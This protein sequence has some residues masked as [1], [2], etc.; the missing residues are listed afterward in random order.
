MC[1]LSITGQTVSAE[2]NRIPVAEVARL[3]RFEAPMISPDGSYVAV[4]MSGKGRRVVVVRSL[5]VS[6]GSKPE[7]PVVIGSGR[8]HFSWYD[9]ANNDRLVV[10][11]RS[12]ALV[13]G[14]AGSIRINTTRLGSVGRDGSNPVIFEAEP[15]IHGYYLQNARIVSWLRDDPDHVLATV[16][17][18]ETNW[19]SPL[20]HRIRVVT[21][22]K[23]LVQGNNL[24]I[25]WWIADDSGQIRIGS[26]IDTKAKRGKVTTFYRETEDSEWEQLQKVDFFNHDRLEPYRF[27]EEDPGILLVTT[28][29]L[30]DDLEPEELEYTLFSYDLSRREVT[31]KYENR[32][33]QTII[34]TVEKA[35]PGR[36]VRIVSHD[37]NKK[38]YFFRTYSDIVP[39]EYFLLDLKARR[40]DYVA[41]AYPEIADRELSPMEKVSYASRDGHEIPAFLT[42]PAGASGRKGLPLVVYPH[43]GPWAHDR[44]GFDNYVQFFASR[45]YAVFQPQF[46]GSTGYGI[47]HEQAGYG[48][49]GY[50][51]QEDITDGV[52]WLIDEGV[53]DPGRICIVGSSFGGYAAAVGLAKN[54]EL[55]KCGVSINGVLDLEKMIADS[56]SLLFRT[57]NRAVWNSPEEAEAV[58]PYRLAERMISPVLLIA[59]ERDTVVPVQHS[60][61]MY[62]KLKK[63][64]KNVSYVELDDGEHWRTTDKHEV[65]K[66]KKLEEF[67]ARHIG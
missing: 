13:P 64:G 35:L 66:L 33:R 8:N 9:W 25:Q 17:D 2:N 6:E 30:A 50:R 14:R 26:R 48:Q 37:E 15:N 24:G 56:R 34:A 42:L 5:A 44:W 60:R 38:I 4:T 58:S 29:N 59:S 32:H 65:I 53:A 62:K 1:A 28:A 39:S 63:L 51:I 11:I 47:E 3:P 41:S 61:K 45:G 52:R 16:D 54:P 43:G 10:K 27:A 22:E 12:S 20:V 46:R 23:S 18:H 19:L 31:G 57:I 40:L 55:Y 21:G 7:K 49:W 67:L 36:E